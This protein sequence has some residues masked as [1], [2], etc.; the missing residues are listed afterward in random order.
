LGITSGLTVALQLQEVFVLSGVP[1]HTFVQP[2]EY[3]R[4][5]VAVVVVLFERLHPNSAV[6]RTLRDKFA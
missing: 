6:H 1:Q 5:L 2:V 3:T 4:L